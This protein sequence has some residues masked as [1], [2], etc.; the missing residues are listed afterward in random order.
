ML[1]V[2]IM[3]QQTELSLKIL[4]ISAFGGASLT[5]YAA[6]VGGVS[7]ILNFQNDVVPFLLFFEAN[8]S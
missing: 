4:T 5:I 2:W 7:R 1:F 8:F 3:A 6:K